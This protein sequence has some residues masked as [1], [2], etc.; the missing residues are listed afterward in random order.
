MHEAKRDHIKSIERE[1]KQLQ[2]QE[3]ERSRAL[4]M[5]AAE[6]WLEEPHNAFVIGQYV[7]LARRGTADPQQLLAMGHEWL[8]TYQGAVEIARSLVWVHYDVAQKFLKR[9]H[10]DAVWHHLQQMIRLSVSDNHQQAY[11][12]VL[13]GAMNSLLAKLSRLREQHSG[14]SK[15]AHDEMCETL[16]A[17]VVFLLRYSPSVAEQGNASPAERLHYAVRRLGS[18]SE[19]EVSLKMMQVYM[20]A[21]ATAFPRNEW[22]VSSQIR[23][24]LR[25]GDVER[26]HKFGE[27]AF[28]YLPSSFALAEVR[29]DVARARG[30]DAG[31][32]TLL[33]AGAMGE[34][35]P[36]PWAKLAGLYEELGDLPRAMQAYATALSHH[37]MRDAGKVW[38]L[39]FALC[40]LRLA[41]GQLEDAAREMLLS[42]DSRKQGG[43]PLDREQQAFLEESGEV[44][45]DDMDRLAQINAS[46]LRRNAVGNYRSVR[47]AWMRA[48]AERGVVT[49]FDAERK[50]GFVKAGEK[51]GILLAPVV[52]GLSVREGDEV[53]VIMVPSWDGKKRRPGWRAAWLAVLGA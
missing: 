52:R 23:A 5:S 26:A 21:A 38:R 3:P 37:D 35:K 53:A 51:S 31:A 1:A 17:A 34:K 7:R 49:R 2:V 19:S 50:F 33:M 4:F 12:V 8:S 48:E 36:W 13:V 30:D 20:D 9:K 47:A 46:Q 14:L 27:E 32:L 40:R 28:A 16:I 24:W 11:G 22:F 18:E 43:W 25:L 10:P 42:L 29:A 15:A 45:R 6:A 41:A 39:H 44:F